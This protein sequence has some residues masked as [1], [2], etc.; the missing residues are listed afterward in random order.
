MLRFFRTDAAFSVPE[1]YET[2]EAEGYFYA[3]RLRSNAVVRG[4][5]A[6]LLKCPV[7]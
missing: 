1:F 5:I 6:P 2:L 4:K 7:G 3:I